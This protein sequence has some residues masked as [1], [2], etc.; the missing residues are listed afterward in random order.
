VDDTVSGAHQVCVGW[1]VIFQ[2][3]LLQKQT[4]AKRMKLFG[5]GGY[6]TNRIREVA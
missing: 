3:R 5:L 6:K 1:G 4:F 2:V